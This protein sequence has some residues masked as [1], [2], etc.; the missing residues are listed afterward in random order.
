MAKIEKTANK[1]K[2]P[3]AVVTRTAENAINLF[4]E[5]S[6]KVNRGEWLSATK[7]GA[8]KLS[9]SKP[10][11]NEDSKGT[12]KVGNTIYY[13]VPV[14]SDKFNIMVSFNSYLRYVI[15]RENL[16]KKLASFPTFEEWCAKEEKS[17]PF[18]KFAT[19][20]QK[21]SI[22]EEKK[23]KLGEISEEETE[24]DTEE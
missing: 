15:K 4:E 24:E 7:N 6:N 22:Y 13:L 17:N 1:Q 18:F 19:E 20:E 21:R 11:L 10:E 9:T 14:G 5:L 16:A 12:I 23:G 2:Q 3:K 8:Y